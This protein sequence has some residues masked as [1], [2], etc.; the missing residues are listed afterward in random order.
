MRILRR[1]RLPGLQ[2]NGLGRG[3]GSRNGASQPVRVRRLRCREIQRLRLRRRY[4]TLHDAEVQH[5]RSATVLSER[6][7]L[8][9]T[10]LMK[11]SYNWIKEFVAITESPEELGDRFTNAGLAVDALEKTGGDA[12][13]ELDVATNRPDCLSH[14]GVAREIAAIYGSELKPPKADVREI[15]KPA[16]DAFSISIVD[17]DLCSRYCGR[18]FA[19]VKIGPSPEWLKARLEAMG[20]RSIN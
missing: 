14:L 3:D 12:I 2:G 9:G 20:V 16:A 8:S 10:I 5:Q 7:A 1:H 15:E 17:S 6:H 19:D 13:F 11:I 4:R 18:Y